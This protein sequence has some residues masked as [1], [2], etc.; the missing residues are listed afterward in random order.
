MSEHQPAAYPWSRV[1]WT[2]RLIIGLAALTFA[3][4]IIRVVAVWIAVC[5]R[6]RARLG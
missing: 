6:V 3:R 2:D 5:Q 4:W 1:E